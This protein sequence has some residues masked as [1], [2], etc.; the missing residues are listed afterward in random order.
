[1]KKTLQ[2]W[3]DETELG[4]NVRVLLLLPSKRILRK[5][6]DSRGLRRGERRKMSQRGPLEIR[7]RVGI[8][9]HEIKRMT[10]LPSK[11]FL[12]SLPTLKR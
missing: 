10:C 11:C 3:S 12:D 6:I 8:Q 4:K 9:G 7:L 5:Q 1:M 2:S